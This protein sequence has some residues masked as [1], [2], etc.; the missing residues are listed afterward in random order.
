MSSINEI[1]NAGDIP[2]F[3]WVERLQWLEAVREG[4]DR[5]GLLI[6]KRFEK[7]LRAVAEGKI[8]D[9]ESL[10]HAFFAARI[11]PM[12][13]EGQLDPV[14]VVTL[15][16]AGKIAY[17][18]LKI[19]RPKFE[20][21]DA[22]SNIEVNVE[23]KDYQQPYGTF[24]IDIPKKWRDEL[25]REVRK[26]F[27]ENA[28]FEIPRYVISTFEKSIE[29]IEITMID[30]VSLT[31]KM[32]DFL[33]SYMSNIIY[34]RSYG[35]N[36]IEDCLK[37][38]PQE[39]VKRYGLLPMEECDSFISS[40][41]SR[42][43]LN[44]CL[45]M[46]NH[47]GWR[48]IAKDAGLIKKYDKML[49]KKATEETARKLIKQMNSTT[50]VEF[51]S[52]RPLFYIQSDRPVNNQSVPEDD[53]EKGLVSRSSIKNHWRKGHYKMQAYGPERSLRKLIYI[54]AVFVMP[55]RGKENILFQ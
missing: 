13:H 39:D 36:K 25:A 17:G 15:R 7:E 44:T 32:S 2:F 26:R 45:I 50:D 14:A 46:V 40:R 48:E 37:D 27:G 6:G 38:Q 29:R 34:S 30:K 5:T 12:I 49:K 10:K 33:K 41:L 54:E 52:K 51:D 11:L 28:N 42:L 31:G 3:E 22:L 9:E 18:G 23:I 43:I 35:S 53:V 8:R 20:D 19:A 55:N 24:V 1:I 47:T 4:P 16:T 21:C